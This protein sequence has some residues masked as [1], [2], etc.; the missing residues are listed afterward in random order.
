MIEGGK[1]LDHLY[2]TTSLFLVECRNVDAGHHLVLVRLGVMNQEDFTIAL[3]EV[4]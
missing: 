1:G 4:E 3:S 2:C